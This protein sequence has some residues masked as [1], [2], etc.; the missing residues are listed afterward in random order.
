ML[1]IDELGLEPSDRRL[2]EIIIRKFN[3][4]PVGLQALAASADEEQETIADVHEPYLLQLGFID[5]TPRGRIAT[6]AAYAHMKIDYPN[7]NRML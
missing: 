3:G 4:G 2:L 1:E 7:D 5:R 6:K